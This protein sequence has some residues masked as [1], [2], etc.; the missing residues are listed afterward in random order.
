MKMIRQIQSELHNPANGSIGN[1][2]PTCLAMALGIPA[3]KVPHFLKISPER[4]T[5]LS[6]DW[7]AAKGYGLIRLL[8]SNIADRHVHPEW[9]PSW[10]GLKWQPSHGSVVLE[11]GISNRSPLKKYSSVFDD[12]IDQCTQIPLH[13]VCRRWDEKK[14][15]WD[16]FDPHPA[17]NGFWGSPIEINILTVRSD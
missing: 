5:E 17:N 16:M 7:L 3:E 14:K 9:E 11:V 8:P 15:D 1:C 6:I 12:D 4:G 2:W 10:G 13:V